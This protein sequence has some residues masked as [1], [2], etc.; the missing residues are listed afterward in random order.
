M[1]QHDPYRVEPRKRL[2]DKKRL[3]LL[4]AN[5]GKCCICGLQ[6][7]GFRE[8]WDDY[9]L[10]DIPFVDEHIK[11]LWRDGTNEFNNR[12]P[13]HE[14]C[15]TAK[16]STEATQRAK[17]RDTAERH[18]GAKRPKGRPM[19]GSRRSGLKRKMDGS[20]EPR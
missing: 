17:V 5:G 3:E 6:I 2:S 19:P 8:R 15:A 4:I 12:G 14:K 1:T 7:V 16:T 13:A 11:P 18:F 9:E 10:E 20:V